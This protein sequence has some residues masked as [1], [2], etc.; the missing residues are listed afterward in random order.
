MT[1]VHVAKRPAGDRLPLAGRLALV[2]G[3]GRGIGRGIALELL[4][5]GARVVIGDLAEPEMV[6]TCGALAG[7]GSVDW[8]KLDVSDADSVRRA[9]AAVVERH[10]PIEILVNNAGIGKPGLFIDDD[11]RT[12]AKTIAVDLAGALF[13]TREVLPHM[14]SR[15]WGRIANMSSMM[16]FTGSP[17]FAV[18]SAAKSGILGFSEALEREL[19]VHPQVRVTAI[20]PPSVQT[21]AFA[22]AKGTPIMR[23]NLV[24][25]VTVEQ[26]ARRTVHGIISGRRRVY[27]AAQSYLASLAQRLTPFVMDMVLMYMFQPP[28]RWLPPKRSAPRLPSPTAGA[29]RAPS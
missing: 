1:D 11:A 25:P 4:R 20:L 6:E 24:P 12:I 28:V 23:W 7:H 18:Y 3:G 10:G 16:A 8:V 9:V 17:G 26:V 2:T 27:C 22:D 29:A 14:V 19:R 13:L 21:Q 15:G 5:A